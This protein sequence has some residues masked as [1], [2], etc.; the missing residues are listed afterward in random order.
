MKAYANVGL[1][2][3]ATAWRRARTWARLQFRGE[4]SQG[5]FR[6]AT[7]VGPPA[8]AWAWAAASHPRRTAA[9][10]WQLRRPTRR[11]TTRG[12]PGRC[13]AAPRAL[14]R[15]AM[16]IMHLGTYAGSSKSSYVRNR[17]L[18]GLVA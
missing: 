10:A 18:W 15:R 1:Q 8:A 6:A 16:R 14:S 12:I 11:P 2:V 7:G 3:V 9:A 5:V 4:R 13:L 17:E